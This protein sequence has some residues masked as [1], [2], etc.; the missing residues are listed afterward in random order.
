V[1]AFDRW[2][3]RQRST[4][5]NKVAKTT[6]IAVAVLLAIILVAFMATR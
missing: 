3:H 5:M 2:P 1:D 6:W 4:R